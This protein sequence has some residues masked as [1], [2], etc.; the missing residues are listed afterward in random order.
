MHEVAVRFFN[1][2]HVDGVRMGDR[3][4]KSE[5]QKHGV[6]VSLVVVVA[7]IELVA[8]F[9]TVTPE[10]LVKSVRRLEGI[11]VEGRAAILDTLVIGDEIAQPDA[12]ATV[13]WL[14]SLTS[15]IG[16]S[17]FSVTH[18]L[19]VVKAWEPETVILGTQT[20]TFGA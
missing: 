17:I 9:A 11:R 4:C 14:I 7:V 12:V 5:G 13:A 1:N 2:F 18:P 16:S 20:T 8:L 3:V 6:G 10:S 19:L 15:V